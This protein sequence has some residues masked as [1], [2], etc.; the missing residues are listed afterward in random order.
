MP[1]TSSIFLAVMVLVSRRILGVAAASAVVFSIPAV[2][3]PVSVESLGPSTFAAPGVFP[4][5]LYKHYYNNPT[6]TSAQPQPVITD[7]V[8][9]SQHGIRPIPFDLRYHSRAAHDLPI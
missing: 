8:L 7:P 3:E 1:R 2:A 6:A 5:S 9:V 4:T